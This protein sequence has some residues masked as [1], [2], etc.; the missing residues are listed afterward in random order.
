MLFNTFVLP[1]GVDFGMIL[2]S[3]IDPKSVQNLS[4][5][6]T[7]KKSKNVE[8]PLFFNAFV[9]PRGRK[10]MK[11]RSKIASQC[12]LNEESKTTPKDAPKSLQHGS[13]I[14]PSWGHVGLQNRLR[15]AQER[16]TNRCLEVLDGVERQTWLLIPFKFDL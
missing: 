2:R 4:Q 3:R 10:L 14:D 1:F 16:T 15:G 12:I 9:P 6:R 8:K 7:R 13:K 11:N 5:E